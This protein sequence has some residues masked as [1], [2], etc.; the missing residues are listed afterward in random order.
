MERKTSEA[1]SAAE[2][3]AS[4]RPMAGR[5]QTTVG[6]R[7]MA[8]LRTQQTGHRCAPERAESKSDRK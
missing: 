5:E 3:R 8:K 4:M 2:C 1:T 6:A 7:R